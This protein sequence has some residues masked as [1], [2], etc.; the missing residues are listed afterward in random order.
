MTTLTQRLA[1]GFTLFCAATVRADSSWDRQQQNRRDEANRQYQQQQ[2]RE[3]DNRRAYAAQ[4]ARLQE[5]RRDAAAER[6]RR[7]DQR[8]RDNKKYFDDQF[9]R[10]REE[11]ALAERKRRTKTEERQRNFFIQAHVQNLREKKQALPVRRPAPKCRALDLTSEVRADPRG[12][13]RATENPHAEVI[14][15]VL[16]PGVRVS[17]RLALMTNGSTA[18]FTD[19][20][21]HNCRTCLAYLEFVG[22]ATTNWRLFRAQRGAIAFERFDKNP[23]QGGL[24]MRMTNVVLLEWDFAN[25]RAVLNGECLSAD[26]VILKTE[27][28]K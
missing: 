12:G 4:Q 9:E 6:A 19:D 2:A 21:Q 13:Y 15:E 20:S 3:A 7:E 1:L 27:W 16:R 8:R 18:P 23:E 17:P 5:N 28:K 22:P 25:D 24:S 10:E 14:L 26:T 11:E